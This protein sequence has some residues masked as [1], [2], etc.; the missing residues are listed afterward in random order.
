MN[1]L[2]L[3]IRRP[4]KS[5]KKSYNDT[6]KRYMTFT[7][8]TNPNLG[9]EEERMTQVFGGRLKGETPVSSSRMLIGEKKLIAGVEVP[10]KP[11][12]PDNCC[13]SGC[14]DCVWEFY[15]DDVNNWKIARDK[16]CK[17]IINTN[18]K[19][20]INWDPPINLLDIKNLP[21]NLINKKL[22]LLNNNNQELMKYIFPKRDK[23]LP[24]NIIQAK[25]INIENKKK[26]RK[27][28]S[29]EDEGWEGIPIYIRVFAEFEKKKKLVKERPK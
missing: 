23:P 9:S 11:I 12:P 2:I 13:M 19:W 1:K 6:F 4:I 17:K 3:S 15:K 8:N 7:G 10:Q 29:D 21:N 22:K 25:M 24:K 16:A 5:I 14:V 18:E 20:P 26:R 27:L 28:N